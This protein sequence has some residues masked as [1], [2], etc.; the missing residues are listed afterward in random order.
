MS[1]EKKS[2]W[3]KIYSPMIL[4][5]AVRNLKLNKF[6][7]I[8]SMIGIV[9]GVFAICGM[10][11]I[12]A[13]F[14]EEMN[15][16]I[17]DT[18]D[19][20]TIS[21]V[22]EKVIDGTTTSGFSAKD[23]RDIESAV[24]SVTKEYEFIPMYSSTKYVY[25]GKEMA[26]A[27]ISG[28]DSQDLEKITTLI[29]GTL[30]R[31][32]TNV[33][34]GEQFAEDN[35]L[36]IGSRM[37]MLNSAGQE[38]TSRVVGIL[39][40]TG[41]MTL[42]FSTSSAVVGSIEWYTGLVGD[43][44]GLYDKVIVKAYDPTELTPIDDAIEKKMNGKKDKDSDDTVYILNSYEIMEVFDEI[45]SMSSIFTTII[46]GI[47]LLVAAVAITNVM[48]MSVKERTR[49]VGILRSIGTYRSQ[50]LQMFLYE[51]GLI[52]LIGAIA[53]TLLALI[54]APVML[55]GMIGSLDAMLTPAVLV[56]VPIGILI[57]LI[58]CLISGLYPAW[59]AANLNPVEAMS[60]D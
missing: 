8:L 9:I 42:G 4:S 5:L 59:K 44:H 38:V 50:I 33:V 1:E 10:G 6:R 23:L 54:A 21:P 55:L 2:L 57:G 16:M 18:A 28:M 47:S 60:T 37:I 35:N 48:L 13:G 31:G 19:T 25:I 39:E 29:Q 32:S 3:Q 58:V 34:V 51:A 20:L 26:M 52:G 14:T 41:M 15:S 12:S 7:T 11:M 24:K 56:Y 27:S 46:S 17:S 36:R 22:G 49:E 43:N 30:P 40:D 45:M 53:G